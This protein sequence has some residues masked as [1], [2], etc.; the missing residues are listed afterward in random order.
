MAM[1]EKAR[2]L[3][4]YEENLENKEL[5]TFISRGKSQ[6]ICS[7]ISIFSISS[8]RKPWTAGESVEPDEVLEGDLE[9]VYDDDLINPIRHY[10]K[11][12]GSMALFTRDG[13]KEI[14]R[15]M[16]EAKE[17]IKQVILSFPGTVKELLN[18]LMALKKSRAAV[19]DI[20]VE[21]R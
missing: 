12:M 16:E 9:E 14:A 8:I 19:K 10:I 1:P 6:A 7:M 20:T 4:P 17:E 15:Q 11:E 13:E 21:A 2:R 3:Y 18:A 5:Y